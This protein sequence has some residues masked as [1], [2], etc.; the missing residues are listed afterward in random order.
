MKC[1]VKN[2]VEEHNKRRSECKEY[3]GCEHNKEDRDVNIVVE[4][5]CVN[6]SSASRNSKTKERYVVD[7]IKEHFP[8]FPL[9][10]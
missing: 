4:V 5:L 6:T 1:N 2:M 7:R 3:G 10:Y 8:E 9:F